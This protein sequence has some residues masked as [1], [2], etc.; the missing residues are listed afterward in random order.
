MLLGIITFMMLVLLRTLFES[1][2]PV[3]RFMGVFFACLEVAVMLTAILKN[4]GI[5]EKLAKEQVREGEWCN[6]C[7][8]PKLS[9]RKTYH[10]Q[11]CD[12]C[13]EEWDHHCPWF[14]KCIGGGN[15]L[16]FNA[17]IALF[18][19]TIFGV[20]LTSIVAASKQ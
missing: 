19:V 18:F 10:C 20:M 12:L 1:T 16:F 4:P 14:G 6:I 3:A 11:I 8:L 17:F 5:P 13:C 2:N 15:I 9:R 7:E